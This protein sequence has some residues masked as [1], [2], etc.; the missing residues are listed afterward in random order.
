MSNNCDEVK[1][2]VI[3]FAKSRELV[4]CSKSC[5]S[6]PSTISSVDL[7]SQVIAQFPRLNELAGCFT[8]SLNEEYIDKT[9][10]TVSLHL[11]ENDEIAVIPPI[12]GG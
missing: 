3:F 2:N 1:V 5:V 8:L 11:R 6:L 4:G 9:D 10:L 7:L 12:S